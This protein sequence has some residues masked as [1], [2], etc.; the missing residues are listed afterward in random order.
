MATSVPD[1]A[2]RVMPDPLRH[3]TAEI[4][5]SVDVPDADAWRIAECLVQVDLR[6]VFSHGTRQIQKYTAEY[7]AGKLNPRPTIRVI[8]EAPSTAVL[9]GDGGIGYLVA[10]RATELVI[11]KAETQ[12]IA[13]I[14]TR[15]HGHVGSEGI[16]ARMALRNSLVTFAV[17][18]GSQWQPSND[19]EATVWD[20]MQSPPMCF[21][22]PSASGPPLV[23]DM[24]ANMFR[25]RSRLGK[26][27]EQFPEAVFKSLGLKFVSTLL[28]GALAGSVP[29]SGRRNA[30]PDA[31]RGFLIVAFRLAPLGETDH[32]LAEVTRIISASRALPPMPGQ[33]SAEVAGSI[34]WQREQ[35]WSVEGIPLGRAHRDGIEK[36]AGD[37][38][39]EVPW[40]LK[41]ECS[42]G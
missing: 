38:G 5:R 27:M 11:E 14:A 24:S 2:I 8:S 15:Y 21:G 25:D 42:S 17:A 34:E 28:G 4:F 32:F 39:V 7:R 30:F 1:D 12:G 41:P 36:V 20:A 37:L 23:L 18:G 10:T 40:Q 33:A 9:D 26:A 31:N 6:G 35:D 3:M 19:P 13:A 29:A 16:Y 22:I